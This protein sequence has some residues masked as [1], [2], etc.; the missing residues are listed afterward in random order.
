MTLRDR[1]AAGLFV[2]GLVLFTAGSVWLQV[3]RWRARERDRKA[4]ST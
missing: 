2:V 3:D 4:R 1:I